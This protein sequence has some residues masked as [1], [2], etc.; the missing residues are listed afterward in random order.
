L[1]VGRTGEI[2][3]PHGTSTCVHANEVAGTAQGLNMGC[4]G[5]YE[6]Q[7]VAERRRT[8]T[9][10]RSSA[11]QASLFVQV[12]VWLYSVYVVPRG[13]QGVTIPQSGPRIPLVCLSASAGNDRSTT[14]RLLHHIGASALY[15]IVRLIFK[16]L[17]VST[18]ALRNVP[19]QLALSRVSGDI[20][21]DTTYTDTAMG[22]S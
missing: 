7:L 22:E 12:S 13:P 20:S 16:A 17:E 3:L 4:S 10:R 15:L 19:L 1:A 8:V 5:L 21:R 18:E 2:L 14:P 6:V 9:C 11:S